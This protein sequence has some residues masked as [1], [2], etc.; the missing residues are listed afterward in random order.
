M[1]VKAMPN[2]SLSLNLANIF[3]DLDA[4]QELLSIIED[5]IAY[6]PEYDISPDD[7][8]GLVLQ[9]IPEHQI[10]FMFPRA[11]RGAFL[12]SLFAVYESAVTDI[13][14]LIQKRTGKK[15]SLNDNRNGAFLRRA[16]KYYKDVLQFDLSGNKQA[17]KRLQMLLVLRNVYAHANGHVDMVNK[18][19]MEKIRKYIEKDIGIEEYGGYIIV[20]RDFVEGTFELVKGD[21][22][23]LI[24][25]YKPGST[26]RRRSQQTRNLN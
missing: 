21:L 3:V 17:W 8:D 23:D 1:L 24:E 19:R 20:S 18:Q 13:A 7:Y 25:R 15:C 2:I 12:V 5:R 14:G 4:L 22:E 6:P 11:M 16:K 26:A 9:V 10:E